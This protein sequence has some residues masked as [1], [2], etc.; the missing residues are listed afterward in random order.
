MSTSRERAVADAFAEFSDT[1]VVDFD[2]VEFLHTLAVRCVELTGVQA[3]GVMLADQRGGLRVMASSSEQA[4]LLELFELEADEGPCVDCYTAGRPTTDPSARAR[5]EGFRAVHAVP[6]RLRDEVVGVL[7]LFT[8]VPGALP[9]ADART[10]RAVADVTGLALVQ[11]RAVDYRQLLAEQLHHSLTSRVVV[12]QAKGVLAELLGLDMAAAFTELR[13]FA[14][15]TGRR[16]SDVAADIGGGDFPPDPPEPP[17]GRS[18]VLLIRTISQAGLSKLRAEIQTAVTRHGLTSSQ[19]AAF[20]LAVH[21]AMANAIEHG[22]GARQL[23][24]WRYA[25]S[26]YAEVGDH[27]RGMPGG[28][29]IPTEAPDTRP[30]I[31]RGLWLINRICAGVDI[32][33]SPAGTH[34][35]MRYP[36]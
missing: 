6:V 11:H 9:E 32:E 7:S 36:L 14:R 4:H 3:A 16:L 12:E 29:R 17:A 10:A 23:I 15:S 5:V 2:V 19:V 24:L 28:Y 26:L 18:R 21:E 13:R 27:G 20:T 22:D 34:L 35:T 31:P 33:S 25:G 30:D 8:T 1:L